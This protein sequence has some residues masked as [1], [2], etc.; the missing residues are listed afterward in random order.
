[1]S[2]IS[3]VETLKNQINYLTDLINNAKKKKQRPIK[4]TTQTVPV[5]V[6]GHQQ[7]AGSHQVPR[8]VR[9]HQKKTG[10]HQVPVEVRGHQQKAKPHHYVNYTKTDLQRLNIGQQPHF[11][12]YG[13]ECQKMGQKPLKQGKYVWTKKSSASDHHAQV[14]APEQPTRL[15]Q[16]FIKPQ[17]P[18]LRFSLPVE[19]GSSSTSLPLPQGNKANILTLQSSEVATDLTTRGS[20]N[21]SEESCINNR[22]ISN[23]KTMDGACLHSQSIKSRDIPKEAL[24]PVFPVQNVSTSVV[25]VPTSAVSSSK[26]D[27][28]TS[29][30]KSIRT[31]LLHKLKGTVSSSIST[32][33]SSTSIS[34]SR[35]SPQFSNECTSSTYPL[36]KSQLSNQKKASSNKDVILFTAHSKSPEPVEQTEKRKFP[37][38]QEKISVIPSFLRGHL[39]K[40]LT[41]EVENDLTI[42]P[43]VESVVKKS[44]SA[45]NLACVGSDHLQ[46]SRRPSSGELISHSKKETD[47]PVSVYIGAK[48]SNMPLKEFSSDMSSNSSTIETISQSQ[49]SKQP[50]TGT[51]SCPSGKLGSIVDPVSDSSETINACKTQRVLS[52]EDINLESSSHVQLCPSKDSSSVCKAL[53]SD[54]VV[55]SNSSKMWDA[56]F[57]QTKEN[58]LKSSSTGSNSSSSILSEM[59]ASLLREDEKSV[60]SAPPLN[61]SAITASSPSKPISASSR[62]LVRCTKETNSAIG[63]GSKKEMHRTV[64]VSVTSSVSSPQKSSQQ[65]P[66][67]TIL[68]PS[69]TSTVEKMDSRKDTVLQL[70]EKLAK[71]QAEIKR[72]TRNITNSQVTMKSIAAIKKEKSALKSLPTKAKSLQGMTTQKSYKNGRENSSKGS[73]YPLKKDYTFP[74]ISNSSKAQSQFKRFSTMSHVVFDKKYSLNKKVAKRTDS[75]SS[76]PQTLRSVV[77]PS[78]TQVVAKVIKSKYKLW[79]VTS[80]VKSPLPHYNSKPPIFSSRNF[81]NRRR[82]SFP[83]HFSYYDNRGKG[84]GWVNRYGHGSYP[85]LGMRKHLTYPGTRDRLRQY[86]G[87]GFPIHKGVYPVINRGFY[88]SYF[89]QKVK[90]SHHLRSKVIF[91]KKYVLKRLQYDN[92]SSSSFKSVKGRPTMSVSS[93]ASGVSASP[94]PSISTLRPSR[95]PGKSSFVVINGMLYKSSSKSLVKTSPVKTPVIKSAASRIYDSVKASNIVVKK[96]EPK[97]MKVVTVRGVQ[98]QMDAS[99]KTLRRVHSASSKLGSS[100][101]SPTTVKRLDI[102][103]VTFIRNS[104]GALERV[105][106]ANTRVVAN[107]VIHRSIAAATA[108][109]RK[110]NNTQST[111]SKQYCLFFNRFGKCKRGSKCP[112]IHDPDKVAVCTRFLRGTC[113]MTGCPFSHKVVKEKMPVC[114]Y[115]LRGVCNRDNC[116]YLH[117]K[118]NKNAS[119]CPNFLKGFCPLGEK[120]RTVGAV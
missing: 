97:S 45:Q 51:D 43:K 103:G 14:I 21:S 32:N 110:R 69:K 55:A 70:T 77:T 6:R 31:Q 3:E 15:S 35:S 93:G 91:D 98:F 62:S 24:K 73:K 95:A 71:T 2:K 42:V 47:V 64:Q 82:F 5:E 17:K 118:V 66:I 104:Q 83:R 81:S 119:V 120:V 41:K 53:K 49:G 13:P 50:S 44:K 101:Q 76:T 1:M 85:H 11:Q 7:K 8:E 99:G 54:Q 88:H 12:K 34:K 111:L 74:Y 80:G 37:P 40:K 28:S 4:N 106:S 72:M 96:M 112:Y 68:S 19:K 92:S 114:S 57:D 38:V 78:K 79:K 87:R 60:S 65:S 109:R 33:S 86:S 22:N 94:C 107:R 58:Q 117:V 46:S 27:I 52:V 20:L 84:H 116:P 61:S 16:S 102:G 67:K 36:M 115:F 18:G 56:N 26:A 29:G 10:P 89:P 39:K 105:G 48:S 59:N 100:H 113:Q 25:H 75:G 90:M 9:G 23:T 30:L 108:L 63:I